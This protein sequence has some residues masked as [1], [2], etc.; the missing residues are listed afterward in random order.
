MNHPM[1]RQQQNRPELEF[2]IMKYLEAIVYAL[3]STRLLWIIIPYYDDSHLLSARL[4]WMSCMLSILDM[5][6]VD[7][8]KYRSNVYTCFNQKQNL[9]EAYEVRSPFRCTGRWLGNQECN[10]TSRSCD[11]IMSSLVTGSTLLP[12]FMSSL[13]L[14]ICKSIGISSHIFAY[15]EILACTAAAIGLS[16]AL[17]VFIEAIR[18]W[19][20]SNEEGGH[21]NTF[22]ILRNLFYINPVAIMFVMKIIHEDKPRISGNSIASVVVFLIIFSITIYELQK[23]CKYDYKRLFR[24]PLTV[25]ETISCILLTGILTSDLLVRYILRLSSDESGFEPLLKAQ[26]ERNVLVVSECGI[27]GCLVGIAMTA[28]PFSKIS[29]LIRFCIIV[30]ISFTFCETG[31]RC[32]LPHLSTTYSSC[33]SVLWFY[34]FVTEVDE[35]GYD[36]EDFST[37]LLTFLPLR[38]RSILYWILV[39]AISLPLSTKLVQVKQEVR[40]YVSTH[41]V[42]ARKYFHGIALL[43][44]LPISA[45][46]PELMTLSYAVAISLLLLIEWIRHNIHHNRHSIINSNVLD[47][48]FRAINVFYAAFMDEKDIRGGNVVVTHI[49]LVLGCA[50]PCWTSSFLRY[51]EYDSDLSQFILRIFGVVS[52]GVGDSIGALI[53]SKCGRLRWPGSSRTIEGTLAMIL[54][55][56]VFLCGVQGR[57][58][59]TIVVAFV[60]VSILEAATNQIDNFVLPLAGTASLLIY[61]PHR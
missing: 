36:R 51:L 5:I 15:I 55:M 21:P 58:N 16:F 30:A 47:K 40:S 27:V 23:V 10:C 4:T 45:Y 1:N 50:L 8:A 48:A 31:I 53:G 12:L 37:H 19:K 29:T 7:W 11:C 28:I 2:N 9:V 35:F 13:A 49:F 52:I 6:I 24:L 41:T 46:A 25:G 54:S 57:V 61:S 34:R 42:I 22:F 3:L 20:N 33:F 59:Q 43:L 18:L 38:L 44:F 60:L 32:I 17:A 39:L 26:G 56:L 14:C